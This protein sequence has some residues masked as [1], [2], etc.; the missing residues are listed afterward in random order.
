MLGPAMA[1]DDLDPVRAVRVV[2]FV[3]STENLAL[4]VE[5][6]GFSGIGARL[7]ALRDKA[8]FDS[9]QA[10]AA[11]ASGPDEFES[12]VVA[13]LVG[14]VSRLRRRPD[15]A[16]RQ[17]ALDLVLFDPV[18]DA[19]HMLNPTGSS[20]WNHL[21]GDRSFREMVNDL[22]LAFP[23]TSTGMLARDTVVFLEDLKR[24]NL[25][26]DIDDALPRV[27]SEPRAVLRIPG[28]HVSSADAG[29]DAPTVRSFSIEELE[30]QF[31]LEGD[32]RVLFSDTWEAPT[33]PSGAAG[34]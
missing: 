20:V 2:E 23:R 29:Y 13:A 9:L 17:I 24:L 27:E 11:I 12:V 1:P 25:V 32:R 15:L 4:A 34:H 8:P 33:R 28:A 19:V 7:E 14:P 21:T 10:I 6:S 31:E 18:C 5:M 16:L 26:I 3:N 30:R 22:A